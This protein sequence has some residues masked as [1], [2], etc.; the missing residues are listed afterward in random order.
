MEIIRAELSRQRELQFSGT[1]QWVEWKELNAE[2][3]WPVSTEQEAERWGERIPGWV[4]LK[5][6][7]RASG[8]PAKKAPK[9]LWTPLE[10]LV[11]GNLDLRTAQARAGLGQAL[12]RPDLWL[13]LCSVVCADNN[14]VRTWS[15]TRF[16]GTISTQ[17]GSTPL[18]SFKILALESADGHGGCSAGNDIG[19]CWALALDSSPQTLP[20]PC[21]IPLAPVYLACPF[22]CY[23]A[24]QP[25]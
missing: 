4:A 10:G 7:L 13:S 15:V 8:A 6:D 19:A 20:G 21:G 9:I 25:H 24:R 3:A 11:L 17:P 22:S 1:N 5:Q 14:H 12:G 2:G 16:R 23:A 18:A